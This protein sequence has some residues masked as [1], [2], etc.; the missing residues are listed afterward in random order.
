MVF[1][2]GGC[3]WIL[4]KFG[5]VGIFWTALSK[6]NFSGINLDAGSTNRAC[7][8][9]DKIVVRFTHTF[10]PYLFCG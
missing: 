6:M 9:Q 10:C 3:F 8:T 2:I 4:V 5:T 7:L 1:R